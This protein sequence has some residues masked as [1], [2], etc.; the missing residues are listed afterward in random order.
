M[1]PSRSGRRRSAC[2]NAEFG[3]ILELYIDQDIGVY[4][5]EWCVVH[6]AREENPCVEN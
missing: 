4:K 3:E 2:N 6:A 5:I 1:V